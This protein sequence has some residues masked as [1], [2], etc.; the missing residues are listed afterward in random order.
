[1][2]RFAIGEFDK[3]KG[4]GETFVTFSRAMILTVDMGRSLPDGYDHAAVPR[5]A[6]TIRRGHG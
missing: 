6:N 5:L 3:E 4:P 2:R 1:M